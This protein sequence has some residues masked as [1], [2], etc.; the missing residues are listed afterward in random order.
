MQKIGIIKSGEYIKLPN[1][2]KPKK[3]IGNFSFHR[4]PEG[5]WR[6]MSY[7]GENVSS[8]KALK[9]ECYKR[10]MISE[11]YDIYPRSSGYEQEREEA[12][13]K[14]KEKEGKT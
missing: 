5:L 1:T 10:G 4:F 7:K 2:I 13:R 9:E 12:S 11:Y 3:R 6:E 14:T 8:K